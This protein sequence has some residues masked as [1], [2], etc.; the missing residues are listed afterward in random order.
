MKAFVLP[1]LLC[2]SVGLQAQAPRT[3]VGFGFYLSQPM[4]DFNKD[5][6]SQPGLGF[7]M[8]LPMDFGGGSVLRPRMDWSFHNIK[9]Y[10]GQVRIE[11]GQVWIPSRRR[12]T[13]LST[14]GLGADYLQYV[15][16]NS[17]RGAYILVG[18][19]ADFW[20]REEDDDGHYTVVVVEPNGSSTTQRRFVENSSSLSGSLGVGVQLSRGLA[21]E[22]RVIT[23]RYRIVDVNPV[24]AQ[25]AWAESRERQALR[26]QVG[27][28]MKW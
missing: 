5:C 16:G 6:D 18:F 14:F 26:A 7:S 24:G 21:L 3:T 11:N 23:S 13:S 1:L 27:M 10:D 19:G 28:T 25:G 15:S 4:G 9:T 12:G 2:G 20:G 22:A 17:R 8:Q